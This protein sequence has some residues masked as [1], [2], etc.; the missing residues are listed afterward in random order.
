MGRKQLTKY[1]AL[2]VKIILGIVKDNI[3]I[4]FSSLARKE[5]LTLIQE[6][7]LRRFFRTNKDEFNITIN[8]SL[9]DETKQDFY[10]KIIQEYNFDESETVGDFLKRINAIEETEKKPKIL[11]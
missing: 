10:N 8:I 11:M 3:N 6:T 9:K 4:N 7:R 1:D 5:K 2:Y